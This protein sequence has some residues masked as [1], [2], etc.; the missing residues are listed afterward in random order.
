MMQYEIYSVWT[1]A[2]KKKKKYQ[3]SRGTGSGIYMLNHHEI[4]H[5]HYFEIICIN[6]C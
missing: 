5:V 3:T 6:I 1:S 2:K 4:H